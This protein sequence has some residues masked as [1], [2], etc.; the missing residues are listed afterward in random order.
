MRGRSE[1]EQADHTAAAAAA[2]G[3]VLVLRTD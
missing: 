2:L 3:N 1:G